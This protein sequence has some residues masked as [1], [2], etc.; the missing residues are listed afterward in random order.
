MD[1]K[2]CGV[3]VW[4][5]LLHHCIQ[6]KEGGLSKSVKHTQKLYELNCPIISKGLDE[7]GESGE[8]VITL[9]IYLF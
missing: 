8:S 5:Q 9:H 2:Q 4:R 7:V 3:M 1:K 6:R